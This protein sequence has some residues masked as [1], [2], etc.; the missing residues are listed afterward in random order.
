MKPLQARFLKGTIKLVILGPNPELFINNCARQG[1]IIWDVRK[2]KDDKLSA[3][4]Y[5]SDL[6]KV[7]RIRKGSQYKVGLKRGQGLPYVLQA[8][9][10]QKPLWLA[11]LLTAFLLFMISNIVWSIHIEGLPQELETKVEKQLKQYGVEPGAIT[12]RLDD[13]AAIQQ[14]L[15]D[16]IPELLWIGVQKKGTAY[17]FEGV[18]K[19]LVDKEEEKSPA[20]LVA[21]KKGMIIS[22]YIEKGKP[23]VDIHDFVKKGEILASGQLDER[24]TKLVRAQGNVFAETWYRLEVSVPMKETLHT[25]TGNNEQRYHLRIGSFEFPVWGW[26]KIEYS[27][28]KKEE[29]SSQ[30]SI[31]SKELPFYWKKSTY[32]E[33]NRLEKNRTKKDSIRIARH[34]AKMDLLKRLPED[35][36]IV[37]ENILHEEVDSGKVKLILFVKVHEN[38][39]VTKNVNQ[40]V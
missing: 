20:H 33:M 30:L 9:S 13:T 27:L 29:D 14:K 5:L 21:A 7:K 6:H 23:M 10:N 19:T 31:F 24:D 40:G 18:E 36:K 22:M 12:F 37:Q 2:L 26:G 35:S 39:A 17:L 11:F 34:Q 4:I 3:C 16:D 8:I 25:T 15:L 38:I 32:Y 1:V 28:V